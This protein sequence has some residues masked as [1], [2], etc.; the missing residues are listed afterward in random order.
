MASSLRP[1]RLPDFAAS[2]P[3]KRARGGD[4]E[5]HRERGGG[6]RARGHEVP[7]AGRLVRQRARSDRGPRPPRVERTDSASS[8]PWPGSS[9]GAAASSN[10]VGCSL[11]RSEA[12]APFRILSERRR[13]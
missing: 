2:L 12:L 4:G 9:G 13:H 6:G 11:G 1:G 7:L 3:W 8:R 5:D 10:L